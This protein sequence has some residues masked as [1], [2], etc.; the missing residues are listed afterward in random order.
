MSSS[1]GSQPPAILNVASLSRNGDLLRRA[2][3]LLRR[4][5]LVAF[6]TECGYVLAGRADDP[7]VLQRLAGLRHRP[8]GLPWTLYCRDS[9][10]ARIYLGEPADLVGRVSAILWPGPLTL[11]ARPTSRVSPS[12][13]SGLAKVAVRVPGHRLAQALLGLCRCPV[14]ACVARKPG[15]TP[16]ASAAEVVQVFGVGLEVVLEGR[17][18]AGFLESAVLDL[19]G[20]SPR[21]I[22]M[23][24]PGCAEIQQVLGRPPLLSGDQPTPG[25][26][27]RYSPEARLVVVEGDSDRV[28][29]RLRFLAQTT[30]GRDSVALVVTPLLGRGTLAGQP[31]LHILP[32]PDQPEEL[33]ARLFDLLRSFENN[34]SLRLVLVEGLPREGATADLMERLT[35]MAHQTL[36]TEDPGYAGQAGQHLRQR[37]RKR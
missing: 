16:M 13:S 15:G 17:D 29:R 7:E 11:L 21:V 5:G 9:P 37:T 2:A 8:P 22:R 30:A 28:A 27:T 25:H 3:N 12:L 14:A 26:F 23:G 19:A 10:E 4:G 24:T 33:A 35:R 18:P 1:G 20:A 31:G 6:P 34:E 32:E 36:N